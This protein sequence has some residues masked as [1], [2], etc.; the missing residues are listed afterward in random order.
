M[1][2]VGTK[3]HLVAERVSDLLRLNIIHPCFLII[4]FVS[5]LLRLNIIHPCFLIIHFAN[6]VFELVIIIYSFVYF[7]V[8]SFKTDESA[9]HSCRNCE[10]I[11]VF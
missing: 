8:K 9:S 7:L 2:K 5:D 6:F 3:P 11:Q 10:I 1:C 4:H